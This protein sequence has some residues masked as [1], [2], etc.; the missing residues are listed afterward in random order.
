M[1][2]LCIEDNRALTRS[3][4]GYLGKTFT[5]HASYSAAEG[6]EQ[7]ESKSYD[8][9]ILD[10]HLP[11]GTGLEVCRAI[12]AQAI[13]TPVLILTANQETVTKV[14]L[15]EA[16][17]DDFLTKPFH[18]LE[19]RARLQALLR[20]PTIQFAA[21]V[22]G[23]RGLTIDPA[24]RQAQREGR[25][26][27]LRRKEFDILEYLMRNRGRTVT[28]G[29][30]FAHVWGDDSDNISNTVDVHVKHL[31]DKIDKPFAERLI[32]TVY[33]LGYIMRGD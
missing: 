32:E 5:I 12:R 25:K 8:L 17:A 11:D 9:I 33:G 30:I 22:L 24:S 26:I 6:L 27:T 18:V 31:R 3:L 15:L 1:R 21:P 4:Q 14:Q 13:E 23:I 19:L 10:L 2:L 7:L 16:G 29:M 20:R 28:R